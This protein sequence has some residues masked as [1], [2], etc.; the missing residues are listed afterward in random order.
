MNPFHRRRLSD[1][2]EVIPRLMV[3]SVPDATQC[4]ELHR[5][6]VRVVVDLRGEVPNEGHWPSD[7]VVRR[8]PVVDRRA[9]DAT[10]LIELARWVTDAVR[11]GAVVLIHCHAGMGRSATLACAILMEVGYDLGDAYRIVQRARPVIALTEPQ[12]EVLRHLERAHRKDRT[13]AAVV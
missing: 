11:D 2:S 9:P 10:V 1:V 5:R 7:V 4:R 12:L 8:I 13:L 6:G 3:G